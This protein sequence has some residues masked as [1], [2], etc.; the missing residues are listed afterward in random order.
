MAFLLLPMLHCNIRIVKEEHHPHTLLIIHAVCSHK[1]AFRNNDLVN[2]DA[3]EPHIH[4]RPKSDSSILFQAIHNPM[5]YGRTRF[6]S[7][8]FHCPNPHEINLKIQRRILLL[9]LFLPLILAPASSERLLI[10]VNV[11]HGS[12][13]TDFEDAFCWFFDAFVEETHVF[14]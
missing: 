12:R 5:A 2:Q 3:M 7:S 9:L 4:Q 11:V 10:P 1:N 8:S 6:P 14:V 13:D